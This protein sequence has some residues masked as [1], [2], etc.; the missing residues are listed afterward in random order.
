MLHICHY[1][2][3]HAADSQFVGNTNNK[4]HYGLKAGLRKFQQWGN[5][6]VMKELT[7]FHTMKV[8][9]P[10]DPKRLTREDRR[11]PLTSLMFLTKK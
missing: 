8:F 10:M 9:C 5:N 11:N 6:A 4:K 1:I 7:Q 2:M 3:L